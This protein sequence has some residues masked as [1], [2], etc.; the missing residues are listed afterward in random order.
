MIKGGFPARYGGRLS[1]VLDIRMKEGNMKEFHGE[2]SIGLISSKLSL[3]GPIK[4]DKTS[5]I[6]SGRRTYID[7]LAR[8]FIN[9][10]NRNQSVEK[11]KKAQ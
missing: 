3:E 4:K 8:P 1:S 6:V 9:M 10:R 11:V 7:V 2:G 5:F